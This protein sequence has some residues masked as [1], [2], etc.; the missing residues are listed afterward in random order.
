MR[1]RPWARCARPRMRWSIACARP[2][3]RA[4]RPAMASANWKR[5]WTDS[6][7]LSPTAE[8]LRRTG[9]RT[10]VAW[11][12]PRGPTYQQTCRAPPGRSTTRLGG[13]SSAVTTL[14]RRGG[15]HGDGM[16]GDARSDR[17]R[18]V[19]LE[20]GGG[21]RQPRIAWCRARSGSSNVRERRA[22]LPDARVG[23]QCPCRRAGIRAED[24]L[25][26]AGVR[27]EMAIETASRSYLPAEQARPPAHGPL[28]PCPHPAPGSR[29]SIVG[30]SAGARRAHHTRHRDRTVHGLGDPQTGRPRPGTRAGIHHL[31][32]LTAPAVRRPA[33]LRFPGRCLDGAACPPPGD[34]TQ[35]HQRASTHPVTPHAMEMLT[36]DERD[37]LVER[38]PACTD[39]IHHDVLEPDRHAAEEDELARG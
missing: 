9:P 5:S 1:A 7:D 21:G 18:R 8:K 16:R 13:L 38:C 35:S 39:V 4:R 12:T 27:V 6:A 26:S 24:D 10:P 19:S 28:H 23:G 15:G 14:V 29:K 17:W 33:G 34:A 3:P 11:P 32:R 2:S 37:R 30:L 25:P 36:L 22:V 20:G 31:G